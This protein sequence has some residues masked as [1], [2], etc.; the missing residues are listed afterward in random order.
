MLL[1]ILEIAAAIWLAQIVFGALAG[2]F[3]AWFDSY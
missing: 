3:D 2:I 1:L